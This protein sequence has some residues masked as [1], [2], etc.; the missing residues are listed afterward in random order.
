MNLVNLNA[1]LFIYLETLPEQL[2]DR[3]N[4]EKMKNKNK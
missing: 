3:Y 1:Y 4:K 2:Q